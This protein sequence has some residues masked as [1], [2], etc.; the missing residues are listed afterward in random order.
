MIDFNELELVVKEKYSFVGIERQ[1]GKLRLCLPKGFSEHLLENTFDAKRD[2]FFL[3][4]RIFDKFK[5][6]CLEKGYLENQDRIRTSDRDGV[7]QSSQGAKITVVGEEETHILYSKLDIIDSILN[8]YDEPKILSL[9]YRLGKS[10]NIDYNQLY[11]FLYRA[12]FLPNGAAYI[13]DMDLPRQQVQFAATDI[14]AMYCYLVDEI[15]QQLKQEIKS[16]LKAL[17]EQFRQHYLRGDYSLFQEQDRSHVIDIL[18]EALE[19]I[20]RHTSVKDSDYWQFYEAIEVFLYGELKQTEEGEIWGINNFHTVW[21]SMCLTYL[22]EE[23]SPEKILFLDTQWISESLSNSVSNT[24]KVIDLS[25]AFKINNSQLVPDAVIYK[26]ID[27]LISIDR[28]VTYKFSPMNWN[29]KSYFTIFY[30]PNNYKHKI[31]IAVRDLPTQKHTVE[32][33]KKI[34]T[35]NNSI[36]FIDKP[37][38]DKFYSY[39]EINIEILKAEQIS[40]EIHKMYY[41]NHV[42]YRAIN[43][44]IFPGKNFAIFINKLLTYKVFHSSLLRIDT[45]HKSKEYIINQVSKKYQFFIETIFLLGLYNM[46]VIDVKYFEEKIFFNADN[47]EKIKATSVRKQFV[48]EYL[49]AKYIQRNQS[50]FSQANIVSEFWLPGYKQNSGI[51]NKQKFMDGY[52]ELCSLDFETLAETYLS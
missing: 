23:N 35:L 44:H 31:R 3:F 41:L 21:E 1:G 36:L 4:Y 49:L 24:T 25:T 30:C 12:V 5:D 42:F 46:N 8:A 6:I 28:K 22:I 19:L 2:L 52:I 13:N 37:L 38:P 43:Q 17:S 27:D 34:Y 33:L 40:D 10:E 48:Y 9:V 47:L 26:D 32:L 29:D 16:E 11:R 15:K 20:D 39:W 45:Q 14:V 50:K 7:I 51:E 18:K